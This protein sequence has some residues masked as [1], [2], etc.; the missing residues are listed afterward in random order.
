M[1]EQLISLG[2]KEYI[3]IQLASPIEEDEC[4]DSWEEE[5]SVEQ[6][7]PAAKAEESL[8]IWLPTDIIATVNSSGSLGSP[9]PAEPSSIVGLHSFT[10]RDQPM[11]D[12]VTKAQLL[13]PGADGSS[14]SVFEVSENIQSSSS[15]YG[16]THQNHP[17]MEFAHSW[18]SE[19]HKAGFVIPLRS[20][21]EMFHGQAA[22]QARMDRT[23]ERHRGLQ[24][25]LDAIVATGV[26]EMLTS[27]QIL[28]TASEGTRYES[29]PKRRKEHT[30]KG[31]RQEA[32]RAFES[33][34]DILFL[35]SSG[36]S[37]WLI[38]PMPR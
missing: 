6:H 20:I 4:I 14:H 22:D 11:I 10:W 17:D 30:T 29:K 1:V 15:S 23:W 26:Q 24:H 21:V 27:Y 38:F 2:E 37:H 9:L 16:G 28:T 34:F 25:E 19:S 12:P 31:L 8:I 5:Q 3:S 18:P 13:L 36:F 32:Q 7:K 35:P 33:K